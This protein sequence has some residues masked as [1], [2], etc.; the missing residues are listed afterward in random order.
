MIAKELQMT[1]RRSARIFVAALLASLCG[2]TLY[3]QVPTSQVAIDQIGALLQEKHTRTGDQQKLGSQLWYA[4]QASRGQA[5]PGVSDVYASAV[6]SVKPDAIGRARVEIRAVVSDGLLNQIAAVGGSVRYAS[7]DGGSILA[8]VPLNA[9]ETLAAHPDV[10]HIAAAARA[11][12]NAGALNSQGYISHKANQVVASG[13][14]GTGVKI[15][16]LSDSVDALAALIT[17]GD[18]PALTT[19]VPG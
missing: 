1:G 3:A 2:Q 12:T 7:V 17:T 11:K 14:D 5:L 18:L 8:T 16:I 6:D 9:L 4:L 13:R 10:R 19:V 15:G